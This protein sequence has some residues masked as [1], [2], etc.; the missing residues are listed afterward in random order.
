MCGMIAQGKNSR[1]NAGMQRLNT[2]VKLIGN[3]GK[4]LDRLN[5]QV[6]LFQ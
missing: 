1:M 2:S 4:F 6:I 3:S 5:S